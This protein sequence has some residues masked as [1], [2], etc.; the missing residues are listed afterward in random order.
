MGKHSTGHLHRCYAW[1][2]DTIDQHPR[3]ISLEEIS[4]LW[5]NNKD[6]NEDGEKYIVESK[7]HRWRRAAE[8][9]FGI[10][11]VCDSNGCYSI[12]NH[13]NSSLY[14]IAR[15][16]LNAFAVNDIIKGN[17][18]LDKQI[19][20][21]D[22][23]S[24]QTHLTTILSA[25]RNRHTLRIIHQSFWRNE[26]TYPTVEPYSLKMFRQRWYLL[27]KVLDNS[28]KDDIGELRTYGLDRIVSAVETDDSYAMPDNFEANNIFA[29]LVGIS[30]I[31][32]KIEEVTIV[33]DSEQA[34]YL[35]TLPLHRSQREVWT[36]E[37]ESEFEYKLIVNEE[38]MREL[39]AY[40][41]SLEVLEPEWL[42]EEFRKE[43]ERTLR[44]Y[45]KS[46]GKN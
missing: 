2:V 29:N 24:G 46:R 31:G 44:A 8:E 45:K 18:A 41:P 7:F 12:A 23:P 15:Q 25:M 21:E 32:N 42:R 22:V 5:G 33:V 3:G 19:L 34:K 27:A 9:F 38:F 30:G 36:G 26:P 17:K 39:R 40:G 37:W 11:I 14:K 10:E 28:K 20:L 13:D 4:Q 1:L 6:V 35:R 43:A 16:T